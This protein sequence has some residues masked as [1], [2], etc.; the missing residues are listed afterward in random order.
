MELAE[1]G[2]V[3]TDE[4]ECAQ[5]CATTCWGKSASQKCMGTAQRVLG[6]TVAM[7]VGTRRHYE[8]RKNP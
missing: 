2:G 5:M 6:G 1:I 8:S 4:S 7:Q 3:H